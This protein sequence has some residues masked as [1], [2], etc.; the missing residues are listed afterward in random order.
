MSDA[1]RRY[2]RKKLMRLAFFPLRL[3][4]VKRNKVLLVNALS[5]KYAGNP[6]S[7]AEELLKAQ[8]G[9]YQLYYA[10]RDPEAYRAL[11]EQTGI[12]FIRFQSLSYFFHAMTA[13][14]LLSNSGGYS[15]LP[16][17]K[18][19]VVINT[20]HGG[21]AYKKSGK[22]MYEDT[23]LFRKDLRLHAK[24]TTVILSTNRRFSEVIADSYLI[25]PEKFWEIGMPRNDQLFHIDEEKRAKIRQSLGLTDG[26]KL[27]LYAPTYRKVDDNYFND[28]IAIDYGVDCPRVCKALETRFGGQWVFG[29]RLHP[30]VVNRSGIIPENALDLCDW[31]DMQDLLLA[32]DAMINDFSSSMWDFMLTGKPC[33]TFAVDLEHYVATT[34]VYTPVSQWPFPQSTDND[35]LEKTI[36]EFDEQSYRTACD[37]HYQAL[38]GCESGR[39][40]EQVAEYIYAMCREQKR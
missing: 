6:K 13:R 4:P 8:P 12:R 36:L 33:F 37:G 26:Q 23:P 30:C 24:N 11:S 15:Y 38:G 3:F 22:D 39:A 34:E 5:Q 10:V 16:M 35:Q 2:A 40:G 27:V 19:Q 17:K 14:V 31:E 7:V 21:G 18:S 1:L 28:S 20:H 9:T 29:Y 32:S 25:E